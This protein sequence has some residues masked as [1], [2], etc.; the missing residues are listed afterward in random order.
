MSGPGPLTLADFDTL[1][2]LDRR[3][4]GWH[5][6]G[7]PWARRWYRQAYGAAAVRVAFHAVAE[8]DRATAR[9]ALAAAC[10]ADGAEA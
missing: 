3:L 4:R 8:G 9:K 2:T 1:A 10:R 6:A 5:L 7:N